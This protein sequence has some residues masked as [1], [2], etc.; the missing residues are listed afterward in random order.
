M[1]KHQKDKDFID[2][3]F[4]TKHQKAIATKAKI[5]K[6]DLIKLKLLHI[7]RNYYWSEQTSYRMGEIFFNLSI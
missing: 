4:M 7:K 1:N 5:E 6:W 3:D 2:K